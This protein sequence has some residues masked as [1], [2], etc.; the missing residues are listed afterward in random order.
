MSNS[1]HVKGVR[2][3]VVLKANEIHT[4]HSC[5]ISRNNIYCR[6]ITDNLFPFLKKKLQNHKTA[7]MAYFLAL[8]LH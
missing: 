5:K 3:R 6:K 1:M 8:T 7:V 4:A 2:S